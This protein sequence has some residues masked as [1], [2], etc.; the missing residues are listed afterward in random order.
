[1]APKRRMFWEKGREEDGGRQK[2]TNTSPPSARVR[3]PPGNG[4]LCLWPL[5]IDS[6][7]SV[8]PGYFHLCDAPSSPSP[9][10]L[11]LRLFISCCWGNTLESRREDDCER[12]AARLHGCDVNHSRWASSAERYQESWWKR[13]ASSPEWRSVSSL[14]S[15]W[16]RRRRRSCKISCRCSSASKPRRSRWWSLSLS[17]ARPGRR[18]RTSSLFNHGIRNLTS[19]SGAGRYLIWHV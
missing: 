8:F 17:S 12:A 14:I 2:W 5:L 18:T 1:M 19:S 15:S 11:N 9:G 3:F 6:C 13:G 10:W 16:T 4:L 7:H